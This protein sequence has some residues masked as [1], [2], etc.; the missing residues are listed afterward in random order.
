MLSKTMILATVTALGAG[1]IVSA[2]VAQ[3]VAGGKMF[4]RLDTD[5]SG[6]VSRAEVRAGQG[7]I[8][9]RL[10]SD[11]DGTISRQEFEVMANRRFAKFDLDGDGEISL[12]EVTQAKS[13]RKNN[14]T[15]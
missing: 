5:G 3:G 12:D 4:Q 15:N 9:A 11:G 1:L 13:K 7:R 2:A 8:F 6:T 14:N 10:D